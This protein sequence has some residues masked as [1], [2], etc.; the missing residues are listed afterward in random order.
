ME[1]EA[2]HAPSKRFLLE[3][4]ERGMRVLNRYWFRLAE[5]LAG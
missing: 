5:A 3:N 4:F 2:V 1:P